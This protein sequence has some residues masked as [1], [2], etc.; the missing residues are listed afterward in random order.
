LAGAGIIG[1]TIGFN[2]QEL[3]HDFISV[4]FILPENQV[5]T[6]DVAVINGTG[7]LG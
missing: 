7:R 6:G 3:V 4:F 1:G 5:R 2:S